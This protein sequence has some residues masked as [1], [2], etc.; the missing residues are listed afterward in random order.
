MKRSRRTSRIPDS[1]PGLFDSIDSGA[2]EFGINEIVADTVQ[3]L[4]ARMAETA[5]ADDDMS[6][7]VSDEVARRSDRLMF[8]SFGSGSSGNCA[9]IGTR[10]GGVLIDAGVDA[11]TVLRMLKENG[12]DFDRQVLGVIVTHDHSDHVRAAYPLLRRHPEKRLWATPKTLTG[13][14]RRHNISRRIKDYHQPIYKE[15]EFTV[16]PLSITPFETSHDGTDNVGF[17]INCAGET[18]VVATDMGHVTERAAHYMRRATV[19]MVESNYDARM[20][21]AGTYPQY[22]KAR[23]RGER[24]HMDNADTATLLSGIWSQEVHHVMLCHL[25]HD[26]NTPE[27][28]VA[29]ATEGLVQAGAKMVPAHA[30]RVPGSVHLFALPRFDASPLFVF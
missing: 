30:V 2:D 28:A 13:I 3:R 16:G 12:I 20:L 14:L 6:L 24:G 17:S 11:P 10:A 23:I 5:A 4:R 19:L 18:F 29:A 8:V 25:S 7:A 9:Y 15:F 27:L 22:L 26:N 1:H 21:A